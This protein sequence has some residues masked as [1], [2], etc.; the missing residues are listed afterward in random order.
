MPFSVCLSAVMP[1]CLTE[2]SLPHAFFLKARRNIPDTLVGDTGLTLVSRNETLLSSDAKK[3]AVKEKFKARPGIGRIMPEK[4]NELVPVQNTQHT[5]IEELPRKTSVRQNTLVPVQTAQPP[6]PRQMD[7]TQ[8]TQFGTFVY[9]KPAPEKIRKPAPKRRDR[10]P[11][12][13]LGAALALALF[14]AL[15]ETPQ[16]VPTM[17]MKSPFSQGVGP[18]HDEIADRAELHRKITGWKMNRERVDQQFDNFH[19]SGIAPDAPKVKGP[20]V[21]AGVPIEGEGHP[22]MYDAKKP[23]DINPDYPDTRIQYG[24]KEEQ[25]AQEYD[26]RVKQQFVDEFI[27]NARREGYD[28][29]VDRSGNV[30]VRRAPTAEGQASPGGSR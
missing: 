13:F 18:S 10:T 6:A 1:P 20:D 23:T 5:T 21:M 3:T 30:Q 25:E 24:L 19:Q 27:E 9:E 14:V 11:L 12:I 15:D 2:P 28:L 26:A 29:R 7:N 8:L 16:N 4:G 17:Q 22:R